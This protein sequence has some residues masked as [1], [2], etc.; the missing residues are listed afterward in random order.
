MA[1]GKAGKAKGGLAADMKIKPGPS[2]KMYGKQKVVP[3]KSGI[4]GT[5]QTRSRGSYAK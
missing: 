1:K 3:Q 2:G 4:T 5:S